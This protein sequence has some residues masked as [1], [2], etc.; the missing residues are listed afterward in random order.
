MDA[1]DAEVIIISLL[2]KARAALARGTGRLV[3]SPEGSGVEGDSVADGGS[4]HTT[5]S[6]G[7]WQNWSLYATL[8]TAPG[9]ADSNWPSRT[10]NN[11]IS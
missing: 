7:I 8:E 9:L 1:L 5:H 4:T 3:S 10:N 2:I 11:L 6:A